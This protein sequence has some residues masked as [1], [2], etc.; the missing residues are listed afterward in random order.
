MAAK[1]TVKLGKPQL[2]DVTYVN[3]IAYVLTDLSKVHSN[4]NQMLQMFQ[5]LS[6]SKSFKNMH[7]LK[8]A[9]DNEWV[10]I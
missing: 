7:L 6:I 2:L 1:V 9:F 5:H 8:T 4:V 10:K 3:Y